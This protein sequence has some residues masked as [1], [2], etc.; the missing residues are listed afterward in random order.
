MRAGAAALQSDATP[1]R[2]AAATTQ[3]EAAQRR[4]CTRRNFAAH[5]KSTFLTFKRMQMISVFSPVGTASREN[6]D[7][8][9]L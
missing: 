7:E 9:L 4:H 1:A 3:H 2:G 6:A 8:A 5:L